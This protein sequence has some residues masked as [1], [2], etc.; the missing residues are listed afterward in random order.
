MTTKE[1]VPEGTLCDHCH[2][3]KKPLTE[4]NSQHLFQRDLEGKEITRAN[5]H[6]ECAQAWAM[7]NSG[8]IYDEPLPPRL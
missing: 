1:R 3:P 2:D 4:A 8:T 6:R 7:A 5:V